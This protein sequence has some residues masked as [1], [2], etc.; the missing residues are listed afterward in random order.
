MNPINTS[1]VYPICDILSAYEDVQAKVK[2]LFEQFISDKSVA[3]DDRWEIFVN[4]PDSL[5][6]HHQ[7]VISWISPEIEDGMQYE[8]GIMYWEKYETVKVERAIEAMCEYMSED[9]FHEIT[10]E[11]ISSEMEMLLSKNIGSYCYDW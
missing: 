3:L 5:K 2:K 1:E 11:M 7:W 8:G 6:N 10:K 9:N 4:A